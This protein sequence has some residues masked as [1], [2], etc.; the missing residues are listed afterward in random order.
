MN[1]LA[2]R[3]GKAYGLDMLGYLG[4]AAATVP[5]GLVAA[6]VGIG[7]SPVYVVS[8][9]AVPVL[10]AVGIA[11]R[12][13]SHRCATWGMWSPSAVSTAVSKGR[14]RLSSQLCCW[15]MPSSDSACGGCFAAEESP[16]TTRRRH[17][18]WLRAPRGAE[19][20]RPQ[21][22]S[23]RRVPGCRLRSRAEPHASPA[24]PGRR[25]LR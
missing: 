14:S 7:E 17:R 16:S 10:I 25:H 4:V 19:P 8:A 1:P 21:P 18:E 13:E 20:G 24:T 12:A 9:S 6:R 5:M 3:R 23:G 15:S 11:A 2:G 22:P